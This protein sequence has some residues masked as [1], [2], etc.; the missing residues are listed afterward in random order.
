MLVW[1]KFLQRR[2]NTRRNSEEV[3]T[4]ATR[5]NRAL[6][7]RFTTMHIRLLDQLDVLT[8]LLILSKK[9]LMNMGP[10]LVLTWCVCSLKET[11]LRTMMK[12]TKKRWKSVWEGKFHQSAWKARKW[13]TM[14]VTL[15]RKKL[16]LQVSVWTKERLQVVVVIRSKT[17]LVKLN[18][19]GA[20][21]R[22][23]EF[24]TVKL[25]SLQW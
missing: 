11:Y 2:V 19:V 14:K 5:L 12:M 25:N 3:F 13:R 7:T 17:Q 24:K 10:S 20:R 6:E 16:F 1:F 9:C 23:K 18:L 4:L 8:L 22:L 21:I 15:A